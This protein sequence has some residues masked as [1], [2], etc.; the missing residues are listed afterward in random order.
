MKAITLPGLMDVTPGN[1]ESTRATYLS[2]ALAQFVFLRGL[3][4]ETPAPAYSVKVL[5]GPRLRLA[6][7]DPKGTTVFRIPGDTPLVYS[8][9]V[10]LN[11]EELGLGRNDYT[12]R[13]ERPGEL[14]SYNF[15]VITGCSTFSPGAE[16]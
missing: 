5:V 2:N 15:T 12:V 6:Y 11:L 1:K 16:M 8:L 14:H 3:P 9:A 7:D 10:R 4:T 13:I